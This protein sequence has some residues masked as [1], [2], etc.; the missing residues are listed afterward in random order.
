VVI[1]ESLDRNSPRTQYCK[2]STGAFLRSD[3]KTRY[4]A[5]KLGIESQWQHPDEV[6]ALEELPPLTPEQ[7]A[8]MP[9]VAKP[10]TT[11]DPATP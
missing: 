7:L 4:E 10:Q 5:Y 9:K 2:F 11:T 6:R 3:L 1:Q 8:S